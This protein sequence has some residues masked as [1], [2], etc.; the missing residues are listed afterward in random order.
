MSSTIRFKRGQNA[1]AA[2][3]TLQAGEPAF[4]L[5]TGDLYIG[6]GDGKVK[7]P[8]TAADLGLGNVTNESK[9]TMFTNPALTGTPTTPTATPGTNTTQIASTAFVV[10]AITA[11]INSSPAALDTLNELA[12]ALGNDANFAT[13]INNA[14]ALKAPL[15]SP[16]LTGTPTAPTAATADSSTKIATTAF[17][18]AQSYLTNSSDIIIDGGTF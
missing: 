17:V 18:K 8:R 3:L 16:A 4:A 14:L 15:A 1:N 13:T 2:A 10:A 5:D 12:T 9:V 6:N 11:L 7:L